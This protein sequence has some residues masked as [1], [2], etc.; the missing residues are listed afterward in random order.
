[1]S[2]AVINKVVRRIKGKGGNVVSVTDL[3]DIG[4]RVAVDQALSRL[5]KQGRIVRVQRGLYSQARVSALLGRTISPQLDELVRAWA[6]KNI[7]SGAMAANLLG[8]ST[9]VPAKIIY[10]TNGRS[11]TLKLGSHSIKFLNRGPKTMDVK[12]RVSPLVFQS[13]RYFGKDGVAPQIVSRL[14]RLLS[15]K[16]KKEL[17]RNIPLAAAWMKP[18]LE[19]IIAGGRR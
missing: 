8:L 12:G 5:V 13:L 16:D 9:Q 6:K 3:L 18:I 7:P 17:Q 4:T 14:S 19:K 10:Y 11:K 1:M 15:P 2:K